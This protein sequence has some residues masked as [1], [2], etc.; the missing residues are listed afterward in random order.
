MIEEESSTSEKDLLAMAH[1][2]LRKALVV[3]GFPE[4]S[5]T[6]IVRQL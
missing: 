2:K 6:L 3:T 5:D 4:I 1:E